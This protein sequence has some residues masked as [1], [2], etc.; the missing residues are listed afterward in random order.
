[1][2]IFPDS[3]K[4]I[5]LANGQPFVSEENEAVVFFVLFLYGMF[6]PCS[7]CVGIIICC[8]PNQPPPP[9]IQPQ[10]IQTIQ[11]PSTP[12]IQPQLPTMRR[13]NLNPS[14]YSV[15][16]WQPPPYSSIKELQPPPYSSL[17]LSEVSHR[18]DPRLTQDKCEKVQ[19]C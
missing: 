9:I 4:N 10:N 19:K 1:M 12:F 8:P 7:I 2:F 11:Q 3:W 17:V 14:P 15:S 13:A 5:T 18:L 6:F 16:Q